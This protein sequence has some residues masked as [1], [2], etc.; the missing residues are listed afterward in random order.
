M[1]VYLSGM[2]F[3]LSG[4]AP[5]RSAGRSHLMVMVLNSSATA[6]PRAARAF[7]SPCHRVIG[8][9]TTVSWSG[10]P[11]TRPISTVM[12]VFVAFFGLSLIEAL[13]YRSWRAAVFWLVVAL[14]F[15][16]LSARGKDKAV[17]R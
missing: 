15:A 2:S 6:T 11:P 17:Q 13:A 16:L 1:R 3:Y 10:A 12:T 8:V 7:H 5:S 9:G 14:A 4:T